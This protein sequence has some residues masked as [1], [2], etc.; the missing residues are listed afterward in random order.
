[1]NWLRSPAARA[2]PRQARPTLEVLEERTVPVTLAARP[3]AGAPAAGPAKVARV[4]AAGP[5][6][7]GQSPRPGPLKSFTLQNGLAPE[8]M[9]SLASE[10]GSAAWFTMPHAAEGDYVRHY[11]IQDGASP[12]AGSQ[13]PARAPL[14]A[15]GGLDLNV[16]SVPALQGS[17]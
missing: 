4:R 7:A 13:G 2:R 1:M 6:P 9:A 8:Y 12:S 16:S 5:A 11:G 17:G 15:P 3:P 14:L 10:L